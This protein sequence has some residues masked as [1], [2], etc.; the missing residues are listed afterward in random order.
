MNQAIPVPGVNDCQSC[1]GQGEVRCCCD[2]GDRH[3]RECSECDGTG[4]VAAS[5][6]MDASYYQSEIRRELALRGLDAYS[7][8]NL[9]DFDREAG[10]LFELAVHPADAADSMAATWGARA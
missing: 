10:A 3:D 5:V 6:D 1:R 7:L 4:K 9:C 2:C 8:R